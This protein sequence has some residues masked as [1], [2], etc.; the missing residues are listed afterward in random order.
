MTAKSFLTALLVLIGPC[1]GV[2]AAT[3]IYIKNER[4][5]VIKTIEVPEGGSVSIETA[6]ASKTKEQV[7]PKPLKPTD[8]EVY[9]PEFTQDD[10][11]LMKT[12]FA[13]EK[14][15]RTVRKLEALRQFELKPDA[16]LLLVLSPTAFGKIEEYD[17]ER[18]KT[19]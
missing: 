19:A 17:S 3:V 18:L 8:V 4:G 11:A 10:F 2:E 1:G 13:R 6:A 15:I 14:N 12:A 7:T 9:A 16:V 5:E